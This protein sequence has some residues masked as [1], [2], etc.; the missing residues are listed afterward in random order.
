MN[1]DQRDLLT[2]IESFEVDD[3]GC[4]LTFASRLA[5]AHGWSVAY[6]ERVVT[7]YK[8]F[9]FLCM[10]GTAP[11]CPSEDV[12]AAWHLH[13]TYS[14]SYWD[15]FCGSV[16]RRPLHHEPSRG[17]Y[18]EARKH[19]GMYAATLAAYRRA[20]GTEPPTDIWPQVSD[21]FGPKARRQ[22]VSTA[23]HWIIPK[24][25]TWRALQWT[26]VLAMAALAL[27]GC[28]SG[29]NPLALQGADFLWFLIPSMAVAVAAGLLLRS[30]LRRPGPRSGDE[31]RVLTWDQAAYVAGGNP[32][33]TMA[34]IAR[35]VESGAA[36]LEGARLERA[37]V[38]SNQLSPVE[39][40]VWRELPVSMPRMRAARGAVAIEYREEAAKLRND[41]LVLSSTQCFLSG[42][43]SVMPLALV[44]LLL[45]G[46]RLVNA[47][48]SGKPMGYLISTLLLG[49]VAGGWICLRRLEGCTSRGRA[50]LE[51]T[52]RD[53]GAAVGRDV[54][55]KVGVLGS[56]AL[57][58]TSLAL[59]HTWHQEDRQSSSGFSSEYSGDGGGGGGDGGCGGGGCGGCGGCGGD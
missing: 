53:L 8:R 39:R 26:A 14:R 16:L 21:R 5:H 43:A 40:A 55:M 37:H 28:L 18:E 27:P 22:V 59:L 58:G 9:V 47:S 2:R 48:I 46:A 51:R 10:T 7:E 57:S 1:A 36:R 31:N 13:L 6:A 38:E 12:D 25:A 3:P 30:A 23:A 35:L 24:K 20:F 41:G 32:R 45:G 17:G 34:A 49:S 19:R 50:I 44:V 54:G 11:C 42:L 29:L 56:A 52:R 33:L 4:A 15:R